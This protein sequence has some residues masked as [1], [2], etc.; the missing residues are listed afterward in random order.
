MFSL[1]IL[2][3]CTIGG[4]WIVLRVE[5]RGEVSIYV[6]HVFDWEHRF[7]E[8]FPIYMQVSKENLVFHLSEHSG[9]YTPGSKAFVNVSDLD[10]L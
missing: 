5:C 9:D 6:L 2:K 8:D 10:T 3:N 4:E 1:V 7:E